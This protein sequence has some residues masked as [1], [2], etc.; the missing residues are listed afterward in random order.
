M[1][2]AEP[3][4]VDVHGAVWKGR[5]EYE[6][7]PSAK[8]Y[9]LYEMSYAAK[10]ISSLLLPIVQQFLF[11]VT[12]SATT[13]VVLILICLLTDTTELR[14]TRLHP[15]CLVLTSRM[16]LCQSVCIRRRD[17]SCGCASA[18]C[19]RTRQSISGQSLW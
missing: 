1:A 6:L 3:A 19:T 2:R 17:C 16:L 10:V 8:R 11:I 12:V 14:M 9:E 4:V 15:N 5:H 7:V 13:G 18:I